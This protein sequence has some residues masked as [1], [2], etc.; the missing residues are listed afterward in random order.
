[1]SEPKIV[2]SDDQTQ[3]IYTQDAPFDPPVPIT[4]GAGAKSD[5][6]V[7]P[8]H[9]L[10]AYWRQNPTTFASEVWVVGVDGS[11]DHYLG[12]VGTSMVPRPSWSADN[13]TIA[14]TSLVG[15]MYKASVASV[16]GA[17]NVHLLIPDMTY[18]EMS[19]TYSPDGST[20][21]FADTCYRPAPAQC[22][23]M[24]V[25]AAGV[26][27][28]IPFTAYPGGRGAVWAPDGQWFYFVTN[29]GIVY[30][31]KADGSLAEPIV[32]NLG[33]GLTYWSLS[34]HGDKIAYTEYVGGKNVISIVDVDGTNH[35]QL[36]SPIAGGDPAGCYSPSW[37]TDQT[38]VIMHC[39][40]P[41]SAISV[42]M[43][44]TTVSEPTP[45]TIIGGSF[46]S[47]N[48]EWAGSRPTN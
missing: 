36:T 19:P 25:D 32:S 45:S 22:R 1:V 27:P 13:T 3:Q 4:T 16:T 2:Y 12:D 24:T 8:N 33:G 18:G 15:G 41:F 29:A 9:R 34:P 40:R 43:V 7:S 38:A 47:R 44:S 46:R 20:I 42:D 14:F 31:A 37:R 11:D 23:Y 6:V 30:R 10:V 48:P 39:Y 21:L 26:N 17:P 35:R 28:P 5:P